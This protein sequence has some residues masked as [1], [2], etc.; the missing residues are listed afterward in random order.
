[1]SYRRSLHSSWLSRLMCCASSVSNADCAFYSST[2]QLMHM[3]KQEEDNIVVDSL[4]DTKWW[5]RCGIYVELMWSWCGVGVSSVCG[6]ER[7]S[8]SEWEGPRTSGTWTSTLPPTCVHKPTLSACSEERESKAMHLFGERSG[9]GA[10][11]ECDHLEPSLIRLI[12]HN[13]SLTISNVQV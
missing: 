7:G 11:T 13:H 4:Q 8:R 6:D 9:G 12:Q 3:I 1:M 2:Q 5:N 10:V